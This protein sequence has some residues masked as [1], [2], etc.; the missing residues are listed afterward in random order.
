MLATASPTSIQLA[1]SAARV[2]S[3]FSERTPLTERSHQA[4]T[5]PAAAPDSNVAVAF[6]I[7]LTITLAMACGAGIVALAV[8]D[9]RMMLLGFCVALAMMAFI[10]LPLYIA[11]IADAIEH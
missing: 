9:Q 3:P 6:K 11:S 7:V 5:A 2:V 8:L 4:A 1:A 10:G